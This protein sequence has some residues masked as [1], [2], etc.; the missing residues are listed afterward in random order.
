LSNITLYDVS[1]ATPT[2]CVAVRKSTTNNGIIL[3]SNDGGQ[4]WSLPINQL[5]QMNAVDCALPDQCV[6]VG[7]DSEARYTFDGGGSWRPGRLGNTPLYGIDCFA[8][9]NCWMV[10]IGGRVIGIY[11]NADGPDG[12]G[13]ITKKDL[14]LSPARTLL[15]IGCSGTNGQHCVAVGESG[16]V[17]KT[18]NGG[19]SW[20]KPN[21]G[22][23][24]NLNGVSCPTASNCYAVGDGGTLLISEDGG[25]TW[26]PETSPTSENLKDIECFAGSSS[27]FAVGAN[28]IILR[29]Y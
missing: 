7:T 3:V 28:G 13:V 2:K 15:A 9:R 20:S 14:F 29:R 12:I 21:S 17:A 24:V 27:C 25:T 5:Y 1:C 11:P 19:G 6:A 18:T 8:D 22:T 23:I 10:G 16:V 4:S 26:I